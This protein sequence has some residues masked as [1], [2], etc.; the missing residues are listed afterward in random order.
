MRINIILSGANGRMGKE[1]INAVS[2]NPTFNVMATLTKEQYNENYPE[3]LQKILLYHNSLENNLSRNFNKL[4]NLDAIEQ[5]I[6]FIDFST[7]SSCLEYAKFCNRLKIPM[8]IGTTG[9]NSYQEKEIIHLAKSSLILL[10]PNM[11]LGVNIC[12]YL[13]GYLSKLWSK[14]YNEIETTCINIKETHHKHK[15]DAPSGT[16]L[17]I[18]SLIN[19]NF[20]NILNKQTQEEQP[21]LNP[22]QEERRNLNQIYDQH[23]VQQQVQEQVKI[24]SKRLGE[25]KGKHQV[26]FSNM[27]EEIRIQHTVKDRSIFAYGALLAAKWLI[28][29]K[30]NFVDHS[31][32]ELY[33]FF[34]VMELD[35]SK[36]DLCQ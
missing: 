3:Y 36:H 22:M 31:A 14:Y 34:H 35:F 24:I 17:S 30:I 5:N 29:H 11:S 10:S 12:K 8:V 33:N 18:A 2:K 26:T 15:K 28:E 25:V 21:N 7:P 16:A 32:Y 1:I 4:K 19:K 23:R 27:F 20:I 13:I 6:V 9:F